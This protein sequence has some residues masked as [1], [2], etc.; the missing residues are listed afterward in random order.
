MP[1]YTFYRT[2]T[3][4]LLQATFSGT[5]AALA[6][7]TPPGCAA[8]EGAFDAQARR[9]VDGAVQT[10]QPPKPETTRAWDWAWDD[11]AGCW[12]RVPSLPRR[13]RLATDTVH[14]R[15]AEIEEAQARPLREWLLAEADGSDKTEAVQR[16]GDLDEQVKTLR[17][18][19]NDIETAADE[20]ALLRIEAALVR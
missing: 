6:S 4:A 14:E 2:D 19:L 12:D 17:G 8:I 3:G 20:D 10:W 15:I 9:V 13:K 5:P 7:N 11:K 16:V 1:T 18:L